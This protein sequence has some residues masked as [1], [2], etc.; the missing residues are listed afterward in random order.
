M[1]RGR[2]KVVYRGRHVIVQFKLDRKGIAMVALGPKLAEA[3]MDVAHT[4]AMPYAKSISPRSNQTDHE[5]YQDSFRVDAILTGIAP[6][7]IGKPPMLRVGARLMNVARHAAAVEW[8]RKGRRGH[9]VLGRT[10]DHL[11]GVGRDD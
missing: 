5:H 3:V 9:R 10:L 11:H 8:G 6:D 2:G 4:R 7:S 1:A